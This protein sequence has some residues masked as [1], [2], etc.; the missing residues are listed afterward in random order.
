MRGEVRNAYQVEMADYREQKTTEQE[1]TSIHP[2]K[3]LLD[4]FLKA[5]GINQ[6]RLAKNISVPAQRIN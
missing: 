4:E 2:G 3:I 1:L 5:I 6:Y